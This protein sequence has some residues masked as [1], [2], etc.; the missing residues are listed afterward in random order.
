MSEK[1]RPYISRLVVKAGKP[2]GGPEYS[3]EFTFPVAPTRDEFEDCRKAGLSAIRGWLK[4]KEPLDLAAVDALPWKS[5][6]TKEL[7]GSGHTGWIMWEK[8]GGG[9]LAKAIEESPN[10]HLKLGPYEFSF[11]GRE[12]QFISRK[13]VEPTE[14]EQTEPPKQ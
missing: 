9:F 14:P 2:N 6:Q 13:V 7:V 4:E 10:K 5:Y 8:D 1:P 12:G 11:S 3:V